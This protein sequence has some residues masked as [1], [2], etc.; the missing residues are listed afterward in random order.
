MAESF[1]YQ[2]PENFT[3]FLKKIYFLLKLVELFEFF[4]EFNRGKWRTQ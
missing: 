2:I 1:T 3:Y 4:L